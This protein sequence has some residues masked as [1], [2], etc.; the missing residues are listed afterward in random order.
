[1][2]TKSRVLKILLNNQ[3]T[4]TSGETIAQELD[5]SRTAIWKAVNQLK[6]EG[7]NITSTTNLGYDYLPSD[8]LSKEGI[9]L[10]LT[11]SLPDIS[12]I[13]AEQLESTNQTLK[14][15]AIDGA[16]NNT[17]LLTN[18]QTKT[19]GRFGRDYYAAPG[20]QG[21][22]FS[23]L[24]HANK[25]FDEVAQYTLITAVAMART[26]EYFQEKTV[27]IKWVNDLYIEGKKVC[28]ILSEA[29]TDFETQTISSVIIGVGTNFAIP[30][31]EFPDELQKKATSVFPDS[32]STVSRNTFIAK[33]L[34]EFYA[35]IDFQEASSYIDEYRQRSFVIGREVGFTY[36]R[37]AHQGIATDI[38]QKGELV[39]TLNSGEKMT[40]SSGEISLSQY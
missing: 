2:S 28:G 29:I 4:P 9:L 31:T 3:G 24:L 21:L 16:A 22:Y 8:I 17:L 27:D 13:I 38:T 11:D 26:I 37:L 39:V 19:R 10:E 25:K 18:E 5:L 35:I 33:F 15:M 14:K 23:L 32:Q 40:L 36:N 20:N 6:K 7:H 34:T 30:Q 1:M 12:V